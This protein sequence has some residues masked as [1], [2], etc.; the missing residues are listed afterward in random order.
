MKGGG[1]RKVKGVAD[2]I[3]PYSLAIYDI[4]DNEDEIKGLMEKLLGPKTD[5]K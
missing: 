1:S 4:S 5:Q 3:G 2:Q